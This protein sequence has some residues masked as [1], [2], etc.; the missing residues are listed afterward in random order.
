[1]L[2]LKPVPLALAALID[3]LA[4]PEFV[5]VTF[6]DAVLPTGIL[7][8]LMLDGFAVSAA[9]VP[10]PLRAITSCEFVAVELTVMVPETVPGAVGAKVA[11]RAAVPPAAMLWPAETPLVLNPAPT[12][13]T[14]LIVM[15][16][17]PEF[18][19]VIG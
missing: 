10:V 9:C 7:P 16:L 19:S 6:T 13:A 18:V 4:V 17:L 1:M 8:K 11:T 12:T 3:R 15:A 14:L 2:M 5:T